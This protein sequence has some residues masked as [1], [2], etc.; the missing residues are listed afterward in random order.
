MSSA[1]PKSPKLDDDAPVCIRCL[2]TCM[3]VSREWRMGMLRP[4]RDVP[5]VLQRRLGWTSSDMRNAHLCGN[6]YFDL[7]D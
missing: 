7:T 1:M 4:M 6:C 3:P 5:K 2:E